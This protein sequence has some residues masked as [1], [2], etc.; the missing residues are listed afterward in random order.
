MYIA[1]VLE[2]FVYGGTEQAAINLARGLKAKGHNVKIFTTM[3][4]RKD[5]DIEVIIIKDIKNFR[6]LFHKKPDIILFH[7]PGPLSY[8]I[9][10]YA[11]I[12]NIKTVAYYHTLPEVFVSLITNNIDR[13]KNIFKEFNKIA[14]IP[15]KT[16]DGYLKSFYNT[17]DI[18]FCP[19][20]TLTEKLKK[21]GFVN[22]KYLPYGLELKTKVKK[23]KLEKIVKLLYVGQ[24]R[25][26]KNVEF[27][28]KAF[29]QLLEIEK[30]R[31]FVLDIV[32]SG[33]REKQIRDL[34]LELNL[35]GK[36]RFYGTIPHEKL[37]DIYPKYDIYLNAAKSETF[38]LSM[39]EALAYGLPVVAIHSHGSKELIK[40]KKNGFIIRSPREMAKSIL[41]IIRKYK[42]F[43]KEAYKSVE[44]Y[45]IE[46]FV[47]R[48]LYLVK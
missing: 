12:A 38:G 26:D 15:K 31:D 7:S 11:K 8:A 32:G 48:F 40:N 22:A 24:L 41:K 44:N 28:L 46:K 27:L 19:S 4:N 47:D 30:K 34:I 23:R 25:K 33:P 2:Y 35:E 1:M 13:P 45:S 9:L 18:T 21:S 20:K 36:V 14:E 37:E 42:E 6:N 43:S 39:A 17:T 5:S 16:I 3:N 29:S 10:A